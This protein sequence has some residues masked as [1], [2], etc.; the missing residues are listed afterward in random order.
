MSVQ[1]KK[2]N[3]QEKFLNQL[4]KD[5]AP[6]T[7]FLINGI[8]LQG[9]ITVFDSF[10]VLLL[11]GNHCQLVYKHAISTVMPSDP[12]QLFEREKTMKQEKIL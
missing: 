11:R 5:K 4:R 7:L 9:I 1:E 10:S 2:N 8:K 3:L 6:V 12:I